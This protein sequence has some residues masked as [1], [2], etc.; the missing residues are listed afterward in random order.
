MVRLGRAAHCE[1]VPLIDGELA[2][3]SAPLVRS[4]LVLS[5]SHTSK[6]AGLSR[7][8][9]ISTL[10]TS[11][12]GAGRLSQERVQADLERRAG[13]VQLELG[14]DVRVEDA[15]PADRLAEQQHVRAPAREVRP[16]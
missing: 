2:Q 11:A 7:W 12:A 8:P 4:T 6:Q 16:I 15:Q 13:Q 5:P 14:D 9:C 10:T 1:R 3:P